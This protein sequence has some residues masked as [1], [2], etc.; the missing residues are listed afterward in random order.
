MSDN[1]GAGGEAPFGGRRATAAAALHPGSLARS[2][3]P[4][5]ADVDEDRDP[6]R[7]GEEEARV[8]AMEEELLAIT[9]AVAH[10]SSLDLDSVYPLTFR[11]FVPRRGAPATS[12]RASAFRTAADL[13]EAAELAQG[14]LMGERIDCELRKKS[15]SRPRPSA[16]WAPAPACRAT[17]AWRATRCSSAAAA[18]ATR[19]RP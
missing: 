4:L 15:S 16:S 5:A 17:P 14:R 12:A 6:D 11:L 3:S 1:T 9:H 8:R 10:G 13:R 18:A 19:T 2:F 7:L